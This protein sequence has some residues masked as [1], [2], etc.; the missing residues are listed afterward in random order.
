MTL[1]EYILVKHNMM[2]SA[3]LFIS[4]QGDDEMIYHI[5]PLSHNLALLTFARILRR[6]K[7]VHAHNIF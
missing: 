4:P 1:T 7:T 3:K 5:L 2:V 6:L